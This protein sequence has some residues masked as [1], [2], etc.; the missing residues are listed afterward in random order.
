MQEYKVDCLDKHRNFIYKTPLIAELESLTAE[1][2]EFVL[3]VVNATTLSI[4]NA[5]SLDFKELKKNCPRLF[6]YFD[7]YNLNCTV[8]KVLNIPPMTNGWI[9]AD[10][11]NNELALN[12]GLE[13]AADN[14][15]IFYKIYG[16][17]EQTNSTPGQGEPWIYFKED[18]VIAEEIGRYNL[19]TPKMFNNRIPHKVVN[20]TSAR[21]IV[22]TFRFSPDPDIDKIEYVN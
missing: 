22:T 19:E 21:R 2:K 10:S 3:P 5:I 4:D 14:W 13:N 15:N 20:N 11:G 6:E 18:K 16:L 17:P 8:A 12:I 9:H 1:L 7:G